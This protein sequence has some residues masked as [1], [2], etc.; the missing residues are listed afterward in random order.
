MCRIQGIVLLKMTLLKSEGLAGPSVPPCR[1][2]IRTWERARFPGF[3]RIFRDVARAAMGLFLLA[4]IVLGAQQE[5]ARAQATVTYTVTFTGNWN[6]QS[7]PG[8]VVGSAHFTTLIGAVHNSSVTFWRA[9]GTATPGVEAVAELGSTNTFESEITAAGTNVKS[10][11]S[12]SGVGATGT[13]TFDV[14]FSRTHPRLT[15]LSM[16]GPSPDWFVGVSGLSLLSGST[17]RSSFTVDL[18]PYDAGTEDGTEFSLSNPATNPQGTITSIR[19]TGKFTNVRMARL[20]FTPKTP[21]APPP[22]PP[23][24]QEEE[25]CTVS[26]VTD[27]RSLSRFVECAAERIKDS[28]T[29]EKTLRLLDEFRDREGDWNDGS[30]YLVLLTKRGGVYFH[31]KD[32][33]VEDLDWSGVLSCERGGG[34]VL[35]TQEGC[36]IQYDGERRGYAHPFSASHIPLAHGEEEFVL[37]GGFDEIPLGEPFTGMI[38]GPSTQAG[39][40]DTDDELRGFV[41]DAGRVLREAVENPEIDPAQLRGILRTEGPWRG[42]E[43]YVYIMDETGRVIFDGQDRSREQTQTDEPGK[44]YVIDSIE[45]E[46]QEAVGHVVGDFWIYAIKVEVPLDGG[47]E[48]SRVYV[49]GSEYRVEEMPPGGNGNGGW[50]AV[51]SGGSDSGGAFGLFLA[52]LALLLAVSFD[53]RREEEKVR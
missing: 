52:A 16:I 51:L 17:W 24:P 5:L 34:S 8:G 29:F 47:G 23:P 7:T 41:E 13:R 53:T 31:S 26:E 50:G 1:E 19:N 10:T 2:D 39:D 35:D 6:N 28:D 38:G 18:F 30:T 27:D 20:S 40:V 14:T 48:A 36:F 11:V 44:Q 33:E 25:V 21:I 49:V 32:R 9:G 15:L 37:L 45:N 43:V 22:P 42:G 4:A 12:A 46:G 3:S